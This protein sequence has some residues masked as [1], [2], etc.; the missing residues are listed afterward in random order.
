MDWIKSLRPSTLAI[1]S[2][3]TIVSFRTGVWQSTVWLIALFVFIVGGATMAH[4]DLCDR[5][6][7]QKK[8]KTFAYEKGG[9]YVLFVI[10]LWALAILVAVIIAGIDSGFGVISFSL[11]LL[12]LTYTFTRKVSMLSTLWVAFTSAG[13]TLYSIVA[14]PSLKTVILFLATFIFIIAREIFEDLGDKCIDCGYKKTLPITV[15]NDKETKAV[16]ANILVIANAMFLLITPVVIAGLFPTCKA[17]SILYGDKSEKDA[18]LIG[19]SVFLLN[20][21]FILVLSFLGL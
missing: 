13:V 20:L 12:G 18:Q 4:N 19:E 9:K 1:A 14:Q 6:H 3:L 15:D 5:N 8:G 17:V 7:D 10:F 21:V 11:I 2:F 16:G